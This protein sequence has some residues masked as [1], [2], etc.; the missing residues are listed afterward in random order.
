MTSKATQ[1]PEGLL[2]LSRKYLTVRACDE[3]VWGLPV[4]K[5]IGHFINSAKID[6]RDYIAQ[7]LAK[8]EKFFKDRFPRLLYS[9][10]T[11]MMKWEDFDGEEVLILP[12]PG[13]GTLRTALPYK[14]I[15]D[16]PES[17]Y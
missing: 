8:E 10:A 17:S 4:S 16:M 14:G 15:V 13:K 6:L 5:I 2:G 12:S 11:I 9:H 7:E 3:S 1:I